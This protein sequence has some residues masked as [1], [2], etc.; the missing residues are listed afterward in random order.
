MKKLSATAIILVAFINITWSQTWELLPN[1]PEAEYVN[2]DIYFVNENKGWMV[3]LSGF[4]YRTEDGG[5]SWDTLLI[6]PGTAFRSICFTDSLNGFAGNLGPGSWISNVFDT[7]PLYHT[8]DGGL[9]WNPVVNITGVYPAGVCGMFVVNDSVIYAVGRY[10][11]PCAVLKTIDGGQNWTSTDFS[12][13]FD[14]L[15]D[16]W[17]FSP[18]TGVI[19]GGNNSRSVIYY[20]SDGGVNWTKVF[21]NP[22]PFGWHWKV[23]FPSRYVGY[24]SIEGGTA[25]TSRVAKTTDGGLTWA[26]KPL[27]PPSNGDATGIGFINDSVG[28]VGC[29]I[30]GEDWMTTDGGD[31][32]VAFTLDK[33]FNRYRK[34]ND[35]TAYIC[36]SRIWKYSTSVAT[37]GTPQINF[38]AKGYHM[39]QNKPNP[40]STETIITYTIPEKGFVTLRVFDMGGRTLRTLVKKQ[41][42]A[43]TYS[44][45]FSLPKSAN[46][47]FI[48]KLDVNGYQKIVKMT[49]VKK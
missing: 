23:S 43:G 2:D 5:N 33:Q 25:N 46:A 47:N 39:E 27:I 36:G 3:N 26:L 10:A 45:K 9:T 14:D 21:Q 16:L 4:I 31:S 22:E 41:Q 17:F 49:M 20:T 48:S 7:I 32:W 8:T 19:L 37:G 18:D 38:E 13:K 30:P 6:K 42:E 28:W 40:F 1:S 34:I 12:N 24:A 44:Y 15:I 35:S 11:G 29:W